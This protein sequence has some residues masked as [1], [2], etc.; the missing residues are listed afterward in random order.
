MQVEE[1][2]IDTHPLML[3]LSSTQ[4]TAACPSCSCLSARV[5]SRDI[6]TL[7]DLPCYERAVVLRVQGR[8]FFCLAAQCAHQTFAEQF[9]TLAP[10]YARRTERQLRR[11]CQIAFA[12]GGRPGARLAKQQA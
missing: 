3:V 7:V 1:V 8:R 9:A 4:V 12:L 2:G 11:L 5:H 10:A 6:R